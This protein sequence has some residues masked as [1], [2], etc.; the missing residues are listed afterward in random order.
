MT[1]RTVN[2]ILDALQKQQREL[3]MPYGVL[4]QRSGL[5]VSTVQ[6]AMNGDLGRIETLLALAGVLGVRL[7][8]TL[9]KPRTLRARQATEKARRLARFAQGNTAMEGQAVPRD[10]VREVQQLIKDTLLGGPAR[11]LW[12]EL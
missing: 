5:S 2:D 9:E 10:T 8:I 3:R 1:A 12:S 11:R 7:G 6:R 4:A